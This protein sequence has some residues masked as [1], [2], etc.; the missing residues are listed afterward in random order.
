MKPLVRQLLAISLLPAASPAFSSDEGQV[1][2]EKDVRPI[3]KA[4]CF[5]CHGEEE[6]KKGGLD[7]RLARFLQKGGESGP[8]I[9]PG[10]AAKSLLLQV[11]K[12]GEMPKEKAKLPDHEIATIEKW[13]ISGAKTA[14]PEP[15]DLGPEHLFTEEERKWWSLQPIDAPAVPDVSGESWVKGDNP[16][17]AFIA[18]KLKEKGL[19]FSPQADAKTLIRRVTFDL[20]GL[21]PTPEEVRE[22]QEDPDFE[23]LVGRLLAT[24]HYGERWARHWLDVAGYADSDGYADKDM[25]RKHAWRYRD[26]VIRA[27]NSDKPFDNFVREQLAGDEIAI[28]EKLHANSPTDTEK[29]RYEELLSATGFLRMAPDGTRAGPS[30]VTTRNDC[31]TATIKIVSTS[32]YGMTIQC[33]QCHDHRYDPIAQADYYRLRAIFEPGFDVPNWRP[34]QSRLVSLQT[35]VEA[36][37]A[38]KIE[39]EAKK[40]DAERVKKQEEFITDVLE[41]LLA[42]IPDEKK[43]NDMRTAYRTPVKER[44]DEQKKLLDTIPKIRQLN[45][46]SLYLFDSTYKTKYAA[47]LK[48]MAAE[49]AEVRKKKPEIRYAHAFTEVAKPKPEAI[50]ATHVFFRGDYES[51]KDPVEPGDLNVLAG[52]R[53]TEVP[54]INPEIPGE[55]GKITST[56]RRLAFAKSLTD[57]EHPL[58]ARVIVN[59]IWMHHFG[60]GIVKTA[61]D[62]GV[63]GEDPSHPEL[64]DFLAADFMKNGWSIKRLHRQ[65]LTSQTWR[66]QAVRDAKRDEIDP[67]NVLLSRQN[68]RR[69]EAETIRD[70]LLAV[71]GKLNP[72]QFGKPI[73]IMLN[74]D[75]AVVV[76]VDTTDSAG[77]QTGKFI[78]LDGEE[79]RRSIYVQVRRSRPLEMFQTF[80]APDMTEPNCDVRPVTTVSPQSLLLMN[81]TVMRE[82]AQYLAARLQSDG[83]PDVGTKIRAAWQLVY[84]RE[85]S[86]EELKM[87]TD[88]V[89]AQTEFYLAN[90][91]KLEKVAGPAEGEN[92]EPELLALA[93]LGHALISAN[94]FLYID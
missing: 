51:P 39:E 1:Y 93:A 42:E 33:A 62:F 47:K 12:A 8:V 25:E 85:P 59:R 31:I 53:K 44:T 60:R 63:L 76:G 16:I 41:K 2:F 80:D 78:P 17:D 52:W 70:A 71:S 21:P 14:R 18:E 24:E 45:A 92:A 32:L 68:V 37:E 5:H 82:F 83:G 40:I 69:L 27:F 23:K 64:L 56:G 36:A 74:T 88:F 49:A 66:Q 50:P 22:F 7:V 75:G 54:A 72:K 38:A 11:L 86:A 19:E 91:A 55:G 65:I 13:I 3:L 57:G 79:F 67:D 35:K 15:E 28:L 34:P 89:A 10:D 6:E 58:L 94:E 90:P 29:K 9:V 46:G 4:H 84:N 73:P 43:R 81:N 30:D 77:R 20:I 61:G 87:A 48:E 26:Y